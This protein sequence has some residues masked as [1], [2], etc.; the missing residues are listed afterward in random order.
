MVEQPILY[1]MRCL[2]ALYDVFLPSYI[3]FSEG[4]KAF[5][6]IFIVFF[7]DEIPEKRLLT[8]H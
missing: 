5:F 6:F 1:K 4:L 7:P 3:N 8:L 2:Q